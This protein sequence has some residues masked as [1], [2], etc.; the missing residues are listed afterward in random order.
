MQPGITDYGCGVTHKPGLPDYDDRLKFPPR[1]WRA[2]E[3]TRSGGFAQACLP[4]VGALL[5]LCASLVGVN[6]ACEL[7]TAYG[8]GAAWIEAA[9]RPGAS[10]LTIELDHVRATAARELFAESES[11]ETLEGDW[12]AAL[13]RG[14]VDLLFSDG[15]PKRN[16][17]DPE[18]LLPLLRVGGLAVL[19]DYTP[20]RRESDPQSTFGSTIPPTERGSCGSARPRR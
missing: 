9:L 18:K 17:G 10:L 12:T 4:E 3:N 11:V 7:G 1:V 15:G 14:P 8:V 19:D 6:S 5:E 20:D 16:P 2:V 13:E